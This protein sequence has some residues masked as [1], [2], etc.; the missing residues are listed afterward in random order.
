MPIYSADGGPPPGEHQSCVAASGCPD[1]FMCIADGPV[2]GNSGAPGTCLMMCLKPGANDPFVAPDGGPAADA[3][4]GQGGC[5]AG[6]TCSITEEGL[7]AW[8]SFCGP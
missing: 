7:P 3:G 2:S 5:P 8:L 1:G 6:E 4:P